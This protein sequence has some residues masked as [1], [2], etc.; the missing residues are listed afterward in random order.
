V[1]EENSRVLEDRVLLKTNDSFVVSDPQGDFPAQNNDGFGLYRS[2]CRFLST[3]ELRLNGQAPILLSNSVDQAYVATFQ[4]VNPELGMNGS[5]IP[6]QSL[7]LRRTRFLHRGFHER[8]GIKNC[9]RERVQL[10]LQL[11]FAAD[12]QDIFEVRRY[13]EPRT[14]LPE[15]FEETETGFLCTY[16]G[17]D[18]VRR[19]TEI[20]LH[21]TPALNNGLA[22][23]PVRLE[24]HGD[25][26]GRDLFVLVIDILPLLGNQ[27]PEPNQ[28]FNSSLEALKESYQTWNRSCTI[29]QTDN[30]AL[31][32]GLLN[33]NLEDLRVL[34]D[35]R[36]SG[37][38]PT[39]GMPWYAVPFGRDA[40]ITS[41]QALDLNL[42]LAKGSL[43]YLAKHQGRK[44]DPYSEEEP[45]KILHEI[46]FGELANLREIPHTPYYGTIDAT[47][48]FL[49]LLIELVDWTGDLDLLVELWDHIQLALEWIKNYGDLDG[50]GFVEYH[51][52][53]ANGQEVWLANRG[54]KDS[55]D[56]VLNEDGSPP[57]ETIALVEVQG[58]VYQAKMGLARILTRQGKTEL[59]GELETE[60]RL[61]RRCFHEQYWMPD[62]HFFALALD[63]AKRQVTSI[64][65]NPGH[66][67]WSGI[68]DP[69]LAPHVVSRLMAEDMFSGWGIRTLSERSSRYNPMS[70][71]NGSVWPHDNSLIAAG[72]RRYGFHE[73]AERVAR[74][75]LSA[76]M[77][78]P[79]DRIPEL[80]CGFQRDTM[81]NAG[82]A[83]Y[84]VS[85]S[86]QAWG[87]ASLFQFFRTFAGLQPD[88]LEGKLRIDP[89][90][91][92]LVN[93]LRVEGMRIGDG[94]LD[95][96]V[97]YGDGP[98]RVQVDR[99]P[100][101]VKVLEIPE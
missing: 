49:V 19:A 86:P 29:F 61:L 85:C 36:S 26:H 89:V 22:T 21:P 7:S 68:I 95:F 6:R 8:I 90:D 84:L 56:S 11:Q 39:A 78:F 83:Q 97:R 73:A 57:R 1:G 48:L 87:A 12:F 46:R 91:T 47:A 41:F 23:I 100:P 96:T 94:E 63:G 81:F 88:M 69:S 40:I 66:C 93:V 74:S 33:R 76:C 101:G 60:A 27:R 58:Y 92:S 53:L 54:W 32:S 28:D 43:R 62:Q 70:Y 50:D 35:E 13:V 24:P 51:E 3:Y 64:A 79:D 14:R 72:M 15:P 20:I 67:L 44:V 45:G 10:D 65:S 18:R 2:D 5:Q 17:A 25:G 80:Y 9:S 98:P 77:R 31:D 82:P 38:L 75:V 71:H 59:A 42:D 55:I 4:L 99:R 16:E 30:E 52:P 37:L 34:C